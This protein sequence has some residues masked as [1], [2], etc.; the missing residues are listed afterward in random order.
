MANIR[1]IKSTNYQIIRKKRVAA[2]TRVSSNCDEALH[3]LS[4]QTSYYNQ[5]ISSRIDWL[6]ADIY[7]DEG[8]SGNKDNRPEFQRMLADCRSG[9][10]DLIVTKSITRF[11]RNTLVCL[12]AIRE[13]KSLGIDVF[14]EK[15]NIH[16]ISTDG[17]LMLTLLAMFAEEEARSASDNQ[18]WRIKKLYEAGIAPCGVHVYGYRDGGGEIKIVPEEA[19]IVRFI[20]KK[21]LD[22]YNYVQIADELN[23]EKIK[24]RQG[25]RWSGKAVSY[26]LHN[27]YYAGDLLLGKTYRERYGARY[28][29][30]NQG[31]RRKYLVQ[32]D[33]DAIIGREAFEEAQAV[34][35]LE[36]KALRAKDVS[37]NFLGLITCEACGNHYSRKKRSNYHKDEHKYCW[38]CS[39]Y[40]GNYNNCNNRKIFN[41]DFLEATAKNA[42]GLKSLKGINLE[43]CISS[44]IVADDEL[45]YY[46]PSGEVK[47]YL[48]PDR[49]KRKQMKEI[50]E[51]LAIK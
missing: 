32:N 17:E 10:I 23:S 4:A 30:L 44:I 7:I 36:K 26:I 37:A 40:S 45:R 9:K 11:A 28:A 35:E 34:E 31:E 51:A 49:N 16:S 13:L 27:E 6:L 39:T 19:K 15:E 50:L 33:H 3:S 18:N 22:G 21:Y 1:E 42:L 43:E 29:K 20:Y 24:T 14:F 47:V 25:R 48:L 41:D 8:I 2:Y 38:L 5:L 46:L 12:E